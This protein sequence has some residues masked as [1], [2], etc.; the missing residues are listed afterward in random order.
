MSLARGSVQEQAIAT[1][2]MRESAKA[3][4]ER[5]KE[6]VEAIM[7]STQKAVTDNSKQTLELMDLVRAEME[8][9]LTAVGDEMGRQSQRNRQIV[10]AQVEELDRMLG[11]ELTKSLN[12]LGT[13]LAALSNRFVQDYQPLTD[14]LRQVVELSKGLS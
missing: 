10:E 1:A 12:S 9:T 5:T 2:E 8:K 3:L 7:A 4:D 6:S 13:Q 11:E 14:R